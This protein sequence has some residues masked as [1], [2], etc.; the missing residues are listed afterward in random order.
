MKLT[1]SAFT[2]FLVYS[3]P[4]TIYKLSS[5]CTD[6]GD[7]KSKN[8]NFIFK[9]CYIKCKVKGAYIVH[10]SFVEIFVTIYKI[11]QLMMKR[12]LSQ[13]ADN[14]PIQT[15]RMICSCRFSSDFRNTN[16]LKNDRV[17]DWLVR[18]EAFKRFLINNF[19]I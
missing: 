3:L 15:M 5:D 18:K 14:F 17:K 7:I 8:H 11:R 10:R 6:C 4:D 13:F 19:E 16:L 1:F 12:N 2:L 9:I